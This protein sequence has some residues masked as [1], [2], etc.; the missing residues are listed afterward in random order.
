MDGPVLA[1]LA[2][3]ENNLVTSKMLTS[4]VVTCL[5]VE[6]VSKNKTLG[7]KEF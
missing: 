2:A 3:Y 1:V 4:Q 6:N 7:G 5:R